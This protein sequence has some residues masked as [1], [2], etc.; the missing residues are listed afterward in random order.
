MQ[1]TIKLKP[2]ILVNIL[3]GRSN[4]EYILNTILKGSHSSEKSI[5]RSYAIFYF[6]MILTF[7]TA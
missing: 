3:N 2:V 7:E 1:N 4:E 6:I 5:L